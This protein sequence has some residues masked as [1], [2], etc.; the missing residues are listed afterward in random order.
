MKN[1]V[2]V[3]GR[4]DHNVLSLIRGLGRHNFDFLYLTYGNAGICVKSKYCTKYQICTTLQKGLFFL[5]ENYRN[6][7]VKPI[8]IASCDDVITYIDQHKS[9][10][11]TFFLLPGTKKQGDIQKYIDKYTMTKLAEE[12]GI[13]CPKSRF[14]KWNS[15]TEVV[16][17]PSIIK[18]SHQQEGHYNEFKFKI[19]ITCNNKHWFIA[20]HCFVYK[21]HIT[22]CTQSISC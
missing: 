20:F 9:E 13:V 3:W 7:K 22:V 16:D 15:S 17:Y 14:V 6:E 2:I 11:D 18:P 12:I 1:K 8:I 5:L 10:L 21:T 4:D 19:V